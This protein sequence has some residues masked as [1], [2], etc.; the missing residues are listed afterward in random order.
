MSG[1]PAENETSYVKG[2]E[3]PLVAFEI[4]NM[5]ATVFSQIVQPSSVESQSVEMIPLLLTIYLRLP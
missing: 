2:D 4:D 1:Q 3:V 5:K